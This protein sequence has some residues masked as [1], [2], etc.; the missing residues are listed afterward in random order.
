MQSPRRHDTAFRVALIVLVAVALVLL[1]WQ[2][3]GQPTGPSRVGWPV[4]SASK[5]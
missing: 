1:F 3:L 2:C 4:D 5:P